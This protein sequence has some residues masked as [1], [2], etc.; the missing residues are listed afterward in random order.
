MRAE[1]DA[2]VTREVL[3]DR[4]PW[5]DLLTATDTYINAELAE[6]Y[7]MPAPATGFA[8]VSYPDETRRGLLSQGSLLANGAKAG[9]TSP[10]LRGQFVLERLLCSPAPPPPPN[11]SADEPPE[12]AGG[13]NCKSDRYRVHR[14]SPSCNSCHQLMDPVGFGLENYDIQGRFRLHDDGKPECVIDGLGELPGLGSF[15]GPAEL[16]QKLS[17]SDGARRCLVEH[18]YQ[19]AMQ[20][21]SDELDEAEQTTIATALEAANF[22]LADALLNWAS[23]DAFRLRRVPPGGLQ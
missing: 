15:R 9:D 22:S 19:F 1:S 23:S 4:G 18:I 2:L 7:A 3:E 8:W 21:L 14:E 17:Q 5:F 6:V 16:G 13:S 10:T 12:D 20:R 11:V